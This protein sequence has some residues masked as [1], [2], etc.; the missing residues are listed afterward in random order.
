LD[1]VQCRIPA[2]NLI[3]S[4]GF[5]LTYVALNS[6]DYGRFS[7][8]C[9]AVGLGQACLDA[10]LQ[11]ARKRKQ[12]GQPLRQHQLIQSMIAEMVA[13]VKAARLLCYNTGYLKDSGDPDS[14]METWVAKYFATTMLHKITSDAVQIH[15]ANGC[16]N[17]YPVER[18]YRE[19]KIM[20]IIEGTTQ[21][22]EVLIATNAFR[23][24]S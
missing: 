7:I 9:G 3:G 22:H 6:L 21:M 13:N 11:Y 2:K 1:F 8:A 23:H 24:L 15:G 17:E 20:E 10:S 4:P 16:C 19:A 14:I 18:Y 12:F 5:G